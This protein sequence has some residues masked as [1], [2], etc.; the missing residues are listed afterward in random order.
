MSPR[1]KPPWTAERI[2]GGYVVKDANVSAKGG[3]S[4][5]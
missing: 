4:P 1:F 5:A 2:D 3:G